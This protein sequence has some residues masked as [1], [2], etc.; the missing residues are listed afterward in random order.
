MEKSVDGKVKSVQAKKMERIGPEMEERMR[1]ERYTWYRKYT[2][3][4]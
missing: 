2:K 3:G 4:N 1:G